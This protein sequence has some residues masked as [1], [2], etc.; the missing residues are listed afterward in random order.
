MKIAITGATGFIGSHL[1]QVLQSRGDEL[2]CI[3]R[4]RSRGG[5]RGAVRESSLQYATWNPEDEW[6]VVREVDGAA[7]VI[8]LAG[9]SIAGKRWSP[10]QKDKILKSRIHTTQVI[11][12]SIKEASQKPKVLINAS[13][14]GFYGS[15]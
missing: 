12:R 10:R 15:P 2:I 4:R 7:A 14:V 6:S 13:A 9:E 11:A 3:S 8:N 1:A 5:Q